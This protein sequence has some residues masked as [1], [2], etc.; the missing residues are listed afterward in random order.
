MDQFDPHMVGGLKW[1]QV[2]SMSAVGGARLKC[3]Y[4]LSCCIIYVAIFATLPTYAD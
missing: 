1:I 3:M 2:D 4:T